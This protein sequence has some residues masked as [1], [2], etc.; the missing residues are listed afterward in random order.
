MVWQ[1]DF[2]FDMDESE[3][4]RRIVEEQESN[5]DW[6]EGLE[7][8]RKDALVGKDARRYTE[9]CAELG[10]E[11]EDE[12]M[13]Y[14]FVRERVYENFDKYVASK[15]LI[16][17][18]QEL[19]VN[20]DNVFSDRETKI[21]LLKEYGYKR[22][23]V[24]KRNGKKIYVKIE[25]CEDARIGKAFRN[26]YNASKNFVKMYEEKYGDFLSEICAIYQIVK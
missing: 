5:R 11:P 4:E 10:V 24:A 6:A 25:E 9:L 16:E 3:L 20:V 15:R 17:R 23:C 22:L 13:I 1:L 8:E 12:F 19:G 2:G 7:K 21:K 14:D 26:V 18:T